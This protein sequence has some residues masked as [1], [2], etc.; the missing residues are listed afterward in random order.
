MSKGFGVGKE[1]CDMFA[2]GK[3]YNRLPLRYR[4]RS[5]VAMTLTRVFP[6]VLALVAIPSAAVQAQTP[7]SVVLFRQVNVVPMDRERVL[8]GVDVLVENGQIRTIGRSLVTPAGASIVD[9]KGSAYLS[10]G[11]ADLHVHSDTRNDLAI[12]LTHGVTTVLNMGEARNSFVART[13]V[14]ANEGAIPAPH[15]YVA[16]LVDGSPRYGH[17]MVT[18]PDEAR[19]LVRLAKTN[20]YSFIKVYNNLS[21]A[22]FRALLEEGKQQGLPVIGHGVSAVGLDRQLA[23]GQVL[24][25]HTEEFLYTVFFPAGVDVGD[26]APR[27][28]QIP[29]VVAGIKQSGAFVTADLLTY[30]TIS[31]QW[32]KSGAVNAFLRDPNAQYVAPEDRLS[33]RREDYAMKTGSLD[34]RLA[35][36]RIFT[37]AM[38]DAGVPLVTGTDAPAIPGLFPGASLHADLRMLEAAGLSRFQALSAA[39]RIPGNFFA[40]TVPGDERF[41][42]VTPG[43]R[44]DL[45]LSAGNP[46]ADLATLEKPLGVMSAGHWYSSDTLRKLQKEVAASYHDV[47]VQPMSELGG[48]WPGSSNALPGSEGSQR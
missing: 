36:L 12:Y 7:S 32:G 18:T 25:A 11:L 17:F 23:A 33:W 4:S 5:R 27:L 47:L 46:M 14:S 22:C 43:S 40:K 38:S 42:T 10:P 6:F 24:A 21:A 34:A 31:A 29:G 39:T 19:A 30:A 8:Q 37:K 1:P 16:F 20:G 15:V 35:F 26:A 41:G 2:I 3:P 28:D 44:A 45:I 9:G 48:G 13:R